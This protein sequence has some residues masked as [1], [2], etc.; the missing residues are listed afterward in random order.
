M[1]FKTVALSLVVA[2]WLG[3][4]AWALRYA[5]GGLFLIAHKTDP[6]QVQ[7]ETWQEYWADYK[8]DKKERKKLQGSMGFAAFGIF[9]LPLLLYLFAAGKSRSLH[10]DARWATAGEVSKADLFAEEGLILGKFGDKYLMMNE[11][12]FVMLVAPTRSGKGVGTIIPNLLNWNQSV[13]VVD[14]K[15]ENFD[16]TSGF[17]AKHGQEVYKFAPYDEN[18][19]THG[20]NPLT[21]VNR[22]PRF[23]VGELQSIG[24]MLY[25]KRDG[26]GQFWNDAARNLFVAVSLYCLE[27]GY[28]FTIGEVLRRSNG[29]GRPKDFWQ[30]VVDSG[31]AATGQALSKHCLDALSQFVSNSDNTLTSILSTFSAPLGAFANPAV[32]AATSR[33]DF[34]LRDIRRR[35]MTIYVV[36]PPN[37]LAEASLLINLFFSIAIDQNTKTLPEKDRSLK[38]LALLLLDEFPA[39][40]RVDKY[41]KSIGYIAGY[42]LRSMMIAQSISQL[43]DRELYGD[44]GTRTL[45][46]NH[47]VQIIYAPREQQDAQEYSEILGYYGL[48]STSKGTSRGRGSVTNSEN[49]SEQKRALMLPQELREMGPD[50]V[51]VMADNCKPIYG[52]KIKYYA[53]PAFKDRVLPP[54]KV[55]AL[56]IDAFIARSEG[57]VRPA[58][59][60]EQ[61]PAS[62]LAVNL[63]TMPVVTNKIEPIAQEV[64]AVADWL[65]TNVQWTQAATDNAQPEVVAVNPNEMEMVQ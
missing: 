13:I 62:R 5:A 45:A 2:A 38:Y 9:G 63:E 53:D 3:G 23:V 28:Q 46:T 35:K 33:D 65:F 1:K 34:D 41:V 18:F 27:S 43:K 47:M 17:R 30:G 50:R 52:D 59:P 58:E 10:G 61:V 51:I 32:D 36:I 49:I 8:D 57:R 24:Y 64:Q 19:E 40:G 37:R 56:D 55:P 4:G 15:G 44:E 39:L 22:D 29:G 31:V 11:A 25:P 42:G 54:V 48:N 6:R 14:I 12:K 20:S 21:Y 26:D 60:G 7:A 16:A